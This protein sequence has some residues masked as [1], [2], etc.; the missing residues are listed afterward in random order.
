MVQGLQLPRH[1]ALDG[2][3]LGSP[4]VGAALVVGPEVELKID[5][6]PDAGNGPAVGGKGGRVRGGH[7]EEVD[8]PLQGQLHR[9]LDLLLAG[10][11]DGAGAQAQN[12]DLFLPVGELPILHNHSSSNRV[13]PSQQ[14]L[15]YVPEGGV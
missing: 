5:A 8:S 6:I 12:A 1:R 15:L 3:Q 11:A 9:G 14:R 2:I 10:L 7:V 13:G 4:P